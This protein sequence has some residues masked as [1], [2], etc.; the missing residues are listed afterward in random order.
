[1]FPSPKEQEPTVSTDNTENPTATVVSSIVV[2]CTAYPVTITATLMRRLPAVQITGLPASQVRETAERVRSAVSASGIEWP[3]QRVV[4][5]VSHDAP[6]TPSV[7]HLD[8]PIALAV[9]GAMGRVSQTKLDQW[10]PAGELSLSGQL[11]PFAGSL[12]MTRRVFS[13]GTDG[14][15]PRFVVPSG[16]ARRMSRVTGLDVLPFDN[17]EA[18]LLWHGGK[19]RC[20]PLP[21]GWLFTGDSG[22]CMSEVR[23]QH[24]AKR[25]MAVAA[26]ARLPIMLTGSPGSGKTMLAARYNDI[27]PH[28]DTAKLMASACVHDAAN[29]M[30]DGQSSFSRPFRAPHHTISSKG[31]VGSGTTVRPRPGEASLA[32][33]G[34]LFLDELPEFSRAVIEQL[35]WVQRSVAEKGKISFER[36]SGPVSFPADF[37]LVV[38]TN[39]YPC[40]FD[41][42]PSRRC[43]CSDEAKER[44]QARVTD[45]ARSLGVGIAVNVTPVS[46][47]EIAQEPDGDTSES[48]REDVTA[49]SQIYRQLRRTGTIS[50]DAMRTLVQDPVTGRHDRRGAFDTALTIACAVAAL[51]NHATVKDEHVREALDLLWAGDDTDNDGEE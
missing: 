48:I 12:A 21:H 38:S 35:S 46:H 24:E 7:T 22:R 25:A 23:G 26:V 39:P 27:L 19:L 50:F 5:D 8:L 30:H 36:G 43:D 20:E 47:E 3:R 28:H 31:M 34:V 2:G 4:I 44:Y 33:H 42:H 16:V 17:L 13:S 51:D 49:A 37:S 11:R 45:H 9:L 29:L 1:M 14:H 10:H 6:M 41:G 18:V 15:L 32:H 40:G